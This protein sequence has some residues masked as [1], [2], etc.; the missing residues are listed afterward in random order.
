VAYAP[1]GAQHKDAVQVTL[2]QIDLIKRLVE[3]YPNHL[4][5][6][7][8]SDEIVSAH[9]SGRIAS[10][11]TV[12]SGHSIGTSL[13]VLRMFHRLGA[14][15]LTLTHNCNTPWADC[16]K[17]DVPGN[18]AEHNGLTQ[19]GRT[20]VEEMN[21]L[22]MIV[23]LSHSSIQTALDTLAVSDAPVIFSHSSAKA[24]CNS[25]RNIPDNI[26]RLVAEKKGLVMVNFFSYFITCSNHSTV[27]DVIV[28]LNHIRRVAGIDHVGLGASYD[29]INSTPVGLEDVSKYPALFASLIASGAWS[30]DDL[31]KLAG[32]NFLRVFR[33]VEKVSREYYKQTPLEKNIPNKDLGDNTECKTD[34]K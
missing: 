14:R 32:L 28:H 23:D 13:A 17:A 29:G 5:L 2:E 26:L 7:K 12:E 11:I 19:F 15:S 25:S 21:R 1:C 8:T 22:G 18:T 6:V 33:E 31:K 34:Y 24:V 16:S 9:A 4:Q 27:N 10:L 30:L 20:V 3:A